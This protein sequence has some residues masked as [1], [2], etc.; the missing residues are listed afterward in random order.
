LFDSVVAFGGENQILNYFLREIPGRYGNRTR[1][2]CRTK[3]S[4]ADG[5]VILAVERQPV[6]SFARSQMDERAIRVTQPCHPSG[7]AAS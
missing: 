6:A 7:T 3:Y 5:H 4:H 1:T 2:S